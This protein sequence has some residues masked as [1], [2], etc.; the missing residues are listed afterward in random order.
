VVI[1]ALL[2]S[3]ITAVT[4]STP[5]EHYRELTGRFGDPAYARTDVAATRE[6][7]ARLGEL[8]ADD[9]TATELAGEPI[10]ARLTSA[11]GNGEPIG[12]LKVTTE[13]GWFAARPSGTEDVY[14][15]YAESFRG[16]EHLARIQEEA[17]DVV[18]AALGGA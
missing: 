17:R 2:A 4:G 7:K 14:K 3:E 16:A 12:G 9:V 18:S 6:Q 8:A 15:I 5:S 11:P 13:S 1:L 10:T